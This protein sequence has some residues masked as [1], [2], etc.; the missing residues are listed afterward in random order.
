LAGGG[1]DVPRAGFGAK[2][3]LNAKVFARFFF[4]V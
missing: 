3:K 2:Q 4:F 1:V